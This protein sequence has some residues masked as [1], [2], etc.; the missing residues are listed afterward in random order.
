MKTKAGLYL[1]L[2]Y[3]KHM[4]KTLDAVLKNHCEACQGKGN[5]HEVCAVRYWDDQEERKRI[6]DSVFEDLWNHIDIPEVV[7][8]WKQN[9]KVSISVYPGWYEEIR[10]LLVF[11]L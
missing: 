9:F 7:D 8:E 6:I 4:L 3:V 10:D 5:V 2:T 1:Q 11:L